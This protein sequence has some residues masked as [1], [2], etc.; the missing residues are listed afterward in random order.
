MSTAIAPTPARMR[1]SA[2]SSNSTAVSAVNVSPSNSSAAPVSSPS[3]MGNSSNKPSAFSH[4]DTSSTTSPFTHI[5]MPPPSSYSHPHLPTS[6]SYHSSSHSSSIVTLPVSASTPNVSETAMR[7]RMT[8]T[9]S[10]LRRTGPGALVIPVPPT[11][12]NSPHLQSPNSIFRRPH[13]GPRASPGIEE[14]RWLRDTVPL[15]S[16]SGRVPPPPSTS[17]PIVS[18]QRRSRGSSVSVSP[19]SAV[20][21]GAAP[22][23]PAFSLLPSSLPHT[24][25]VFAH[26]PRD[27]CSYP[28]SVTTTSFRNT[29]RH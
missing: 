13:S 3:R 12:V 16:P 1:R 22:T 27:S 18:E 23:S 15:G 26:A 21:P 17:I 6:S 11:L 29:V 8:R 7:S 4:S 24:A 9:N 5:S 14:E 28:P 19:T 10:R 20:V 25:T 2:T